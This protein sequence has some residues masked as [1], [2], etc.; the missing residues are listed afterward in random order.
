MRNTRHQS[1]ALIS[2]FYLGFEPGRAAPEYFMGYAVFH[3]E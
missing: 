1:L 3:V 2:L